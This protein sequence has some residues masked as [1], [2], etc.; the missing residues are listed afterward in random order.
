MTPK[1]LQEQWLKNN[2]PKISSEDDNYV[3]KYGFNRSKK[4]YD[5]L[6]Q[7]KKVIVTNNQGKV[8]I[9]N[10]K[11]N[12]E[13]LQTLKSY[14]LEENKYVGLYIF[15][16]SNE[17]KRY[18]RILSTKY[19]INRGKIKTMYKLEDNTYISNTSLINRKV[20]IKEKN[21]YTDVDHKEL[22]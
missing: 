7:D 6:N 20:Y 5:E 10:E 21:K 19:F 4:T 14:K 11:L 1:E 17:T 16:I 22:K 2:K 12:S 9:H 15:K 13:A 18:F 3:S 8:S